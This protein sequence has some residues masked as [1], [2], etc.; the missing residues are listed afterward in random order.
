[1]CLTTNGTS[2]FRGEVKTMELLGIPGNVKIA[3]TIYL[4]FPKGELSPPKRQLVEKV[5]HREKW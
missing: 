3:A 4:G 5:I 2:K 1:S